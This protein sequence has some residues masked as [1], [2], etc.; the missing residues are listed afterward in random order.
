MQIT[1]PGRVHNNNLLRLGELY[2]LANMD[3]GCIE[4]LPAHTCTDTICTPQLKKLSDL[5][6]EILVQVF[7]I[8]DQ[9][10]TITA[11]ASTS[12]KTYNIWR[13]NTASISSSVLP[14]YIQC[15][16]DA[17]GIFWLQTV[18]FHPYLTSDRD[19]FTTIL[20]NKLLL[21][22]ARFVRSQYYQRPYHYMSDRPLTP[23][24]S[25]SVHKFPNIDDENIVKWTRYY[26]NIWAIALAQNFRMLEAY[27]DDF[28]LQELTELHD[29][30]SWMIQGDRSKT[31]ALLCQHKGRIF[32]GLT[33]T[34]PR[35]GV[36]WIR[37]LDV[38]WLNAY[39]EVQ[40]ALQ[41]RLMEERSG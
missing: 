32:G 17:A 30:V 25:L 20:R 10:R 34:R 12:G 1:V 11:F 21:E 14:R 38:R 13:L 8:F 4:Q 40:T 18:R 33:L 41:T 15:Y 29:V 24:W 3:S 2:F 37:K 22:N 35:R 19:Y 5:T 23:C 7:K 36:K 26:Y 9:P 31:K 16:D 39:G 27:F 6:P 28:T